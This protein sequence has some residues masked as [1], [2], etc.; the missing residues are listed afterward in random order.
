MYYYRQ[1]TIG[2]DLQKAMFFYL[3]VSIIMT[4]AERRLLNTEGST[5]PVVAESLKAGLGGVRMA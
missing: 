5:E 1:K 4:S 2:L 3:I